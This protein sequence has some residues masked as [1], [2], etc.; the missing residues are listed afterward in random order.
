MSFSSP[1][2]WE[3][4]TT[5]GTW[6]GGFDP[7][8]SGADYSQADSPLISRSDATVNS[9][10]AV[11]TIP[12]SGT[13]F[14][15]DLA[16]NTLSVI[17]SAAYVATF[18]VISRDSATQITVDRN[19]GA[20]SAG[21]ATINV[22]GAM[23]LG[24]AS[25]FWAP[26]AGNKVWVKA[27]TYNISVSTVNLTA[28]SVLQPFE[29]EGY[30]TTRGDITTD[31]TLSR[32]I[33]Q[34]SASGISPFTFSGTAEIARCLELIGTGTIFAACT[35]ATSAR[36][37]ILENCVVRA[38]NNAAAIDCS[39]ARNC[40]RHCYIVAGTTNSDGLLLRDGGQHTA[41]F[42]HVRSTATTQNNFTGILTD[43]GG[44]FIRNNIVEKFTY[45]SLF[46]NATLCSGVYEQNIFH[47][48][49][50]GLISRQANQGI[51]CI[52]NCRSNIFSRNTTAIRY[53]IADISA[54]AG[55]INW[56]RQIFDCNFFFSNG[57]N[58][59]QLPAGLGDTTLTVDPFVSESTFD[60]TLN[61]TAGGGRTVRQTM[62]ELVWADGINTSLTVAGVSGTPAVSADLAS[63]AAT[64]RSLWRELTGEKNT[65][66]V[67][68]DT[69]DEYL[70]SGLE[71]WNRRVHYY[72]TT[73][74]SDI[75]LQ[76]GVQEYDVPAAW[77][78]VQFLQHNGKE[79]AKG[80]IEKWRS[81][82]KDW[83]NEPQGFPSQW[84]HY[85]NKLVIRPAPSAAAVTAAA[86]PV[87]RVV[88][89]PPDLTD[90]GPVALAEADYRPVV[91]YGVAQWSIAY[92]DSALAQNRYQGFMEMFDKA[93]Q[94]AALE[95]AQRG[96]GK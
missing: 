70:Q 31:P 77:I 75:V 91:Y 23:S 22:G 33:L 76:A 16:G 2:V 32:P 25:L 20:T 83:R 7:A 47:R 80:D 86:S 71:E 13:T 28:G 11:I 73:S 89:R 1:T 96:I 5:G 72:V 19:V 6:G 35:F 92:P 12:N 82:G 40:V 17:V 21:A 56:A 39:G 79:I 14:P 85:S 67:P 81:D 54:N 60:F 55:A 49:T 48:N 90:N 53:D 69:V 66:V 51:A 38:D 68:D 63:A 59:S 15:A 87:V 74:T 57:T 10:S 27:G 65:T 95:Y 64:M 3:V 42:N 18:Q 58:Y 30:H 24:N 44:N 61:D 93:A 26:V 37:C 43:A 52:L 62:C 94:A 84:A 46:T 36:N 45:G 41:E 34:W 88:A 29:I 8:F 4:R 78:V 50:Y 9:A